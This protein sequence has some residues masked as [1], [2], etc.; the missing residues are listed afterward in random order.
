[1]IG[2]LNGFIIVNMSGLTEALLIGLPLQG[3][4]LPQ[5][6]ARKT[7]DPHKSYDPPRKLEL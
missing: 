7:G 5:T 2:E 3:L 1:M 6:V 4:K